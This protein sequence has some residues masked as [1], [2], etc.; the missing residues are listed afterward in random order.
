[1]QSGPHTP[2]PL[3]ALMDP[4]VPTSSSR[5]ILDLIDQMHAGLAPVFK[6]VRAMTGDPQADRF[7]FQSGVCHRIVLADRPAANIIT[8]LQTV[9][10]VLAGIEE[11]SIDQRCAIAG[12]L[13]DA[14]AAI[15]T[16]Y[17]AAIS[18]PM[19]RD[20]AFALLKFDKQLHHLA[21][22]GHLLAGVI[23]QPLSQW[24]FLQVRNVLLAMA[25]LLSGLEA[26]LLVTPDIS[27]RLKTHVSILDERMKSAAT[28]AALGQV[29]HSA[30]P[31][32]IVRSA[33]S[34]IEPVIASTTSGYADLRGNNLDTVATNPPAA[35]GW[36]FEFS[37]GHQLQLQSDLTTDWP[38]DIG[39]NGF[40]DILAGLPGF[41]PDSSADEAN[42][43]GSNATWP[44]LGSDYRQTEH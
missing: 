24:S 6:V 1:M 39:G 8:T 19:V 14:L 15:P 41:T 35:E 25:D 30:L 17:F 32:T 26:A 4:L 5:S 42:P 21:S 34:S 16:A 43:F 20:K 27:A 37:P 3:D 44:N 29:F 36:T 23:Q 12:Q 33:Q 13:L 11:S 9:K 18:A 40:A 10:M 38:F 7:G 31:A 22:V 28:E 2:S